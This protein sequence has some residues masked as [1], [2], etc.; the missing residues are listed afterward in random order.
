MKIYQLGPDQGLLEESNFLESIGAK[1]LDGDP[2]SVSRIDYSDNEKGIRSGVYGVTPGKFEVF[3]TITELSTI[4]QGR[5]RLTDT[6]GN[7]SEVGPGDSFLVTEGETLIWEV[8]EPTKKCF[9]YC[10]QLTQACTKKELPNSSG[11]YC[12]RCFLKEL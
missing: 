11:L 7:T 12:L 5:L 4:V 6:D 2:K 1:I 10:I 9:Y 8:M 3:Y